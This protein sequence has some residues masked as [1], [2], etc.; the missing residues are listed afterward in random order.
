MH[1]GRLSRGSVSSDSSNMALLEKVKRD[2]TDALKK[3]DRERTDVLRYLLAQAHN[4]EIELRD[5]PISDQD[6]LD[7]F[8][9][10]AKRRREAI[11]LFKQGGRVDLAKKEER[12]LAVLESYLP[13]QLDRGAVEEVI[14]R[15]IKGGASDFNMLMREAM[16]ELKSK[17]DGRLVGEVVKAKLGS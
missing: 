5:K 14:D 6:V 3:G 12:E 15:L 9:K 13:A 7:V 1:G 8:T 4:K 17:A 2:A 11:K 16:K 10:E